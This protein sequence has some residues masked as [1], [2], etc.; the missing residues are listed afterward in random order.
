MYFSL[1]VKN[2]EKEPENMSLFIVL[3]EEANLSFQNMLFSVN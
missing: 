1:F 3:V 2:C